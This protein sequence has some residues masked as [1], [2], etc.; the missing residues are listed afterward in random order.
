M[1]IEGVNPTSSSSTISSVADF[2]SR[3]HLPRL[4]TLSLFLFVDHNSGSLEDFEE[5]KKLTEALLKPTH[6]E[7][8]AVVIGVRVIHGPKEDPYRTIYSYLYRN[9]EP[10]LQAGFLS[11][12]QGWDE[13]GC[14]FC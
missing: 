1:S 10:L 14:P 9:L 13:R 3:S 4:H 5:P 7:L 12:K 11:V 6:P 2:L 8:K